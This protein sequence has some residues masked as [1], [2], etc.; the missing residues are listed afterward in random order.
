MMLGSFLFSKREEWILRQSQKLPS[1]RF[2]VPKS[3]SMFEE[4]HPLGIE[5][6]PSANAVAYLSCNGGGVFR[7]MSTP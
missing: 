4:K 7:E 3:M 2:L 6:F 1:S 5:N